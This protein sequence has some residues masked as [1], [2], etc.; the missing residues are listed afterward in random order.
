MSFQSP[1]A[2]LTKGSNDQGEYQES[3]APPQD[4]IEVRL[5]IADYVIRRVNGTAQGQVIFDALIS[6]FEGRYPH[7]KTLAHCLTN[8]EYLDHND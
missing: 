8:A 5:A 7:H 3:S 6:R 2:V 1:A 4:Q